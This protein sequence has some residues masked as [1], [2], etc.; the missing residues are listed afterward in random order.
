LQV[1]ENHTSSN[2]R[3][4]RAAKEG[5]KK[6][7]Y[8]FGQ[9]SAIMVPV[10]LVVAFLKLTP[11]INY[12]SGLFEPLMKYFGL[13]GSTALAAVTGNFVN[14]YAA[15]AITAGLGLTVRQVTILAI[16]LGVSHSQIMEGAILIKMKSKP[17]TVVACRVI[18]SFICGFLLN[19]ILPA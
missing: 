6:G 7:I 4:L 9:L 11:I 12:I 15:L 16:M 3:L 18:F 2:I 5:I 14:I 13:P 19:I 1:N 8:A 17:W 10:Y